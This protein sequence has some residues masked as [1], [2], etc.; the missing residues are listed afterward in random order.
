MWTAVGT[1]PDSGVHLGYNSHSL[2]PVTKGYL[3]KLKMTVMNFHGLQIKTKY[4]NYL[5]TSILVGYRKSLIGVLKIIF[6]IN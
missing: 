2:E 6:N 5:V 1:A 4:Q 3:K